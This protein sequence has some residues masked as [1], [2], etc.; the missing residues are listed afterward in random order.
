MSKIDEQFL[1]NDGKYILDFKT[2]KEIREQMSKVRD[3]IRHTK[4]DRDFDRLNMY[5]Q[6]L[7]NAEANILMEEER[8]KWLK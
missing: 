8:N 5:F 7:K 4:T 1:G 6:T 3:A 2:V